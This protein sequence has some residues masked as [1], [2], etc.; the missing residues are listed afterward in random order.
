MTAFG[1]AHQLADMQHGRLIALALADDD[2]AGNGDLVER[3]AHGLYGGVIGSAGIAL[4]HGVGGRHGRRFHNPDQLEGEQMLDVE[5][6]CGDS[7][8]RLNKLEHV[9]QFSM[10]Q[11]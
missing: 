8:S 5:R 2:P 6:G 11:A 4:A 1:D 3:A 7:G 10:P 9:Q